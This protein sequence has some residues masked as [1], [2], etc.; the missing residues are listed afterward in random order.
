MCHLVSYN[1]AN[2]AKS[3]NFSNFISYLNKF[4]IF[5][6]FETHVIE[7]NQKMF[8][9]YFK[10]Y[11]LQWISATK[12]HSAGRASGGCLY[13]YRKVLQKAYSFKF[14]NIF[15]NL[16]LTAKLNGNLFYFI[17]RYLNCTNWSNDFEKFENFIQKLSPTNFCIVGDLNARTAEDQVLD[18]E[19]L[20]DTPNI[21]EVRSSS[22]KT[23]NSEG[24]K[25][26]NLM[27]SVGGIILNGRT[28]SDAQGEFS[29]HGARGNTVIDYCICSYSFLQFVDDFCISF[30]PYSDHMPLCLK[31]KSSKNDVCIIKNPLQR[32]RW[33]S[34]Y[35]DKYIENLSR[36]SCNVEVQSSISVDDLIS[37]ITNKI[38]EANVSIVK[39]TFFEP[40]Q[41]WFDWKCARYRKCMK[42]NLKAYR[43]N[44]TVQNKSRYFYSRSKYLKICKTKKLELYVKNLDQLCLYKV[45]IYTP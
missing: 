24:R 12:T 1:V 32:L 37:N 18:T 38:K 14:S 33:N 6:L 9:L 7:E 34:K 29:F 39:K 10:N 13:G 15:N 35:A 23:L 22:D 25:L 5:F 4:D 27:E 16:V 45:L 21:C 41:K 30:K 3:L 42:R 20:K 28:L 8:E 17:P 11:C 31:I 2:L 44:N 19:I 43:R 40:K 26:I 36:L